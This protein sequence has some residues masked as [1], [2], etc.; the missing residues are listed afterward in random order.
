M[1]LPAAEACLAKT[2]INASRPR[3]G[4]PGRVRVHVDPALVQVLKS[5]VGES[6]SCATVST[7]NLVNARCQILQP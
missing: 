6:N 7:E 2:V 4:G 5:S 3:E 1:M